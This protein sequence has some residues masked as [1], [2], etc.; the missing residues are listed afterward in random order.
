MKKTLIAFWFLVSVFAFGLPEMYHAS[1]T[2]R[3]LNILKIPARY[4]QLVTFHRAID[5]VPGSY[6]PGGWYHRE[7]WGHDTNSLAKLLSSD[8]SGLSVSQK[9]VAWAIHILQD[10]KT[11]AGVPY[12]SVVEARKILS[13]EFFKFTTKFTTMR[14]VGRIAVLSIFDFI[15]QVALLDVDPITALK[16]TFTGFVISTGST[17][18]V[19]FLVS[20]LFP[21]VYSQ[22]GRF[23]SFLPSGFLGPIIYIV[24]DITLRAIATGSFREALF[25]PQTLLNSCI[26]TLFFVP[27]GQYIVPAAMAFSWILNW[28]RYSEMKAK[29]EL[30]NEVLHK[31]Y[32]ERLLS[33]VEMGVR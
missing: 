31:E 33:Q 32:Y 5:T 3:V 21:Y 23:L 27:G 26:I 6:A 22:P 12:E 18:V 17:I 4:E 10:S 1:E 13:K 29:Y 7:R 16:R 28:I 14:A 20:R 24:V 2:V 25:S 9:R 15:Y 19:N 30:F 11:K 8:S